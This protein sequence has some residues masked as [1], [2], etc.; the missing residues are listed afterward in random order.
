[1]AWRT[2]SS[3]SIQDNPALLHHRRILTDFD[4]R[5]NPAAG[6]FQTCLQ[7]ALGR[8]YM[9]LVAEIHALERLAAV[10]QLTCLPWV[11][12]GDRAS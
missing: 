8:R 2:W 4:P 9:P 6:L 11:R 12:I 5:L 7:A 1:V 10:Q 3:L